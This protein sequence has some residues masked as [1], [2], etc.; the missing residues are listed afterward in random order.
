MEMCYLFGWL[1]LYGVLQKSILT[2]HPIG[3]T[4]LRILSIVSADS[5]RMSE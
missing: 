3:D 4:Y 2:R 1:M 5:K